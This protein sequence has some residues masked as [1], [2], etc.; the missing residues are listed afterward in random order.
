MPHRIIRT[1]HGPTG[2]LLV[3]IGIYLIGLGTQ[4]IL[5]PSSS[6]EAGVEWINRNPMIPL[7]DLTSTHVAWWWLI[8]GTLTL[9][10]GLAS[11]IPTAERTAIAA[12]IFFPAIVAALFIGAWIDGTAPH[13][14][15][16][17]WSYA[18]PSVVIAWQVSRERQRVE[19]GEHMHTA[20][21]PHVKE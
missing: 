1:I 5:F 13:G 17:A 15:T 10:G 18:L 6:R 8:G 2:G 9:T 21:I 20:A 7:T 14:V 11:N 16:S 19:R 4:W 3:L 12:G